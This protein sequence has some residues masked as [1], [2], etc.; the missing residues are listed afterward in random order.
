MIRSRV[1]P[2]PRRALPVAC[3]L[4]LVTLAEGVAIRMVT[5]SQRKDSGTRCGVPLAGPAVAT[6]ASVSWASRLSVSCLRWLGVRGGGAMLEASLLAG[7]RRA[8]R[9]GWALTAHR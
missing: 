8:G 9:G 7:L 2:M 6:Q 1:G 5:P 4:R 3:R